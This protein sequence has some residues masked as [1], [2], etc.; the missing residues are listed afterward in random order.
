[1]SS[2]RFV[3]ALRVAFD[4]TRSLPSLYRRCYS[5]NSLGRTTTQAPGDDE[6]TGTREGTTLM[7]SESGAMQYELSL[8]F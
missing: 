1:M 2:C 6:A 4:P 8:R 3:A 7:D 5:R